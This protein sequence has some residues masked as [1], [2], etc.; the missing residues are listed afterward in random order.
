ML[1]LAR[2]TEIDTTLPGLARRRVWHAPAV[3]SH[4]VVCLT[5]ARLYLAPPSDHKPDSVVN[6]VQ[7]GGDLEAAFGPLATVI[8]VPSIRRV[9]LDLLTNTLTVEYLSANAAGGVVPVAIQFATYEAADEVFSKVWRRLGERFALTPHKRGGWDLARAPMAFMSGVLL[10]TLTLSLVAN[11]A[12]DAGGA[13]GPLAAF[14]AA[15]W[16]WVCGLG[17]AALAG[18]QVWLYRRLTRPPVKL[19][20]VPT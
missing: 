17:G 11:A 7:D 5:L 19:E 15:D 6:A 2:R 18:L 14:A 8:D 3:R 1:T 10:A 16:R 9:T 4:S 12:A 20:L 13:S